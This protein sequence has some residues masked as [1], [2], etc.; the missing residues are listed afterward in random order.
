VGTHFFAFISTSYIL[1]F[2][3]FPFLFFNFISEKFSNS[4]LCK[5]AAKGTNL[6]SSLPYW[7]YLSRVI[8]VIPQTS[9]CG[10][11]DYVWRDAAYLS[12]YQLGDI[13]DRHIRAGSCT[14]FVA[15]WASRKFGRKMSILAFSRRGW[16]A[17][18][19]VYSTPLPQNVYLTCSDGPV[20]VTEWSKSNIPCRGQHLHEVRVLHDTHRNGLRD[21][22]VRSTPDVRATSTNPTQGM[23]ILD[24]FHSCVLS[25][26]SRDLWQRPNMI[27]SIRSRHIHQPLTQICK[28]P[29]YTNDIWINIWC[30]ANI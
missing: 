30:I 19:S 16:H 7:R 20:L 14:G 24:P 27:I 29:I 5:A 28:R 1:L 3:F 6:V 22:C 21:K 26:F 13:Y 25:P 17:V 18:L 11:R 8:H 4:P 2:I 12:R 10:L 9:P 15:V 23:L